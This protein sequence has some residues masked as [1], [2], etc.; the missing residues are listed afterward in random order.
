MSLF[1]ADLN[2][3][4]LLHT[5]HRVKRTFEY[6]VDARCENVGMLEEHLSD[7]L[8]EVNPTAVYDEF[9]RQFHKYEQAGDYES[10]LRVFNQKSSDKL[11]RGTALWSAEPRQVHRSLINILRHNTPH[12][13]RIRAAVRKCLAADE[14]QSVQPKRKEVQPHPQSPGQKD[15][16]EKRFHAKKKRQRHRD[17]TDRKL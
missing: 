10:I 5:R 14:L 7:L 8:K 11:Q 9:C 15:S 4:A 16:P 2:Q 17:R 12:A 1:K 13:E 3:Q 6:R